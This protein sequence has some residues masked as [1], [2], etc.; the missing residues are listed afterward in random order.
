MEANFRSHWVTTAHM[1]RCGLS[2]INFLCVSFSTV[3]NLSLQPWWNLIEK[4]WQIEFRLLRL[5]LS[6]YCCTE[7]FLQKVSQ[8]VIGLNECKGKFSLVNWDNRRKR[9]KRKKRER[10]K[11]REF[12]RTNEL[13]PVKTLLVLFWNIGHKKA[14]LKKEG[15]SDEDLSFLYFPYQN[16]CTKGMLEKIRPWTIW[17]HLICKDPLSRVY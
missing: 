7:I 3:L 9:E 13:W 6:T 1:I 11:K 10:M 15:G 2:N 17:P 4:C 16:N 8:I 5:Y 14:T 12:A